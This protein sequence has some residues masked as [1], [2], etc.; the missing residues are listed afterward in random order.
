MLEMALHQGIIFS[1]GS[2]YHSYIDSHSSHI[3]RVP[4]FPPLAPPL[5]RDVDLLQ[6]ESY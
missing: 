6:A 2:L 4:V 5:G 3:D 1:G